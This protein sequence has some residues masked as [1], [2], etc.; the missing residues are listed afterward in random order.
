[1]RKLYEDLVAAKRAAGE[2]T[3]GLVYK[4]LVRK[5][6]REASRLAETHGTAVRFEVANVGGKITL[7]ARTLPKPA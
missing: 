5:L 4:A 7:R 2:D 6:E 3:S 1:M